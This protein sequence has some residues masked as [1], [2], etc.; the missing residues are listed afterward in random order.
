MIRK[1]TYVLSTAVLLLAGSIST[2]AQVIPNGGFEDWQTVAG[3]E[4]PKNGWATTDGIGLKCSPLSAGKST[5]KA[6]GNNAIL[7][8]T[9][10]CTLTGGLQEAW[11]LLSFPISKKPDSI[12]FYYKSDHSGNDTGYV[13]VDL[14]KYTAGTGS[15]KIGNASYN[16][17][18]VQSTYKRIAIPITYTSADIPDTAV[19]EIGSDRMMAPKMGNKVWIDELK[20]TSK[21]TGTAIAINAGRNPIVIYP[22]PVRDKFSIKYPVLHSTNASI[23]I[24]DFSGRTIMK[25]EVLIDG[26]NKEEID[27][28][29]LSTGIYLYLL[30]V[31]GEGKYTGKIEKL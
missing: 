30:E 7:L 15:K 5:D 20:F 22:Q 2:N 8:Q 29:Q 17:K 31:E 18:G 11:A 14:Y 6:V 26:S 27:I 13:T 23:T 25:K 28:S 1:H 3:N 4:S 10:N 16:I 21:S 12:S 24:Q 19:V 9:T